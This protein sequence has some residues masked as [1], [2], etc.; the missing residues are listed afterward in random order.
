MAFPLYLKQYKKIVKDSERRA[1]TNKTLFSKSQ[2]L[3]INKL[4]LNIN[5]KVVNRMS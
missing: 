5:Q 3:N 2:Y 4:N 1:F